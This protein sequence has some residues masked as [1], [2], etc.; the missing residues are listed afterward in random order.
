MRGDSLSFSI[1]VVNKDRGIRVGGIKRFIVSLRHQT[2][3]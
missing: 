3:T 2:V 1:V